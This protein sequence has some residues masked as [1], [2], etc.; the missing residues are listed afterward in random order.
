MLGKLVIAIGSVALIAACSS[1]PE[2]ETGEDAEVIMGNLHK[3]DNS[4]TDLAY[5]DPKADFSKYS[6]IMLMPL[7]MDNV[8]I[9][10]PNS[11]SS[12]SRI[13][14]GNWELTEKDK[15]T[16]QDVF[17]NSMVKQLDKKGGYT[18]VTAVDDDVLQVQAAILAIA[19]TAPK[20]DGHSRAA[21][22]SQVY[23][24]GF[25]SIAIMVAF[26]DSETGEVLGLMKD[27]LASSS[28]YW[29]RNNSVSNLSDV[30]NMFDRWAAGIRKGLDTVHEK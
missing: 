14:R 17:H 29:G 6:K 5:V 20:D 11:N 15:A 13:K 1:T 7:G 18:I 4:R 2:I 24:E 25:G 3:V 12:M 16:L 22:R 8:E 23:T 30:R 19:P 9:I 10:Q 28:S 27:S 21:G 26:A